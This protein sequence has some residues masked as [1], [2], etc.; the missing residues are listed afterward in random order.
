MAAFLTGIDWN[1]TGWQK[2]FNLKKGP[3]RYR[4]AGWLLS[5]L[6]FADRY[7]TYTLKIVLTIFLNETV[8]AR[9]LVRSIDAERELHYALRLVT[10]E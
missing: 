10:M 3:L 8:M 6:R 2:N 1:S 5:Y 7:L 4:Q 9:S